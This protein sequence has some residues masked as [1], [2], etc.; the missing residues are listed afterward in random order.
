MKGSTVIILRKTVFPVLYF[1]S[2]VLAIV[3]FLYC[4]ASEITSDENVIRKLN[5]P[6]TSEQMILIV[7]A[8]MAVLLL[9][10]HFGAYNFRIK[11]F[12][13]TNYKQYIEQ[14]SI[15]RSIGRFI[16]V[17]TLYNRSKKIWVEKFGGR[18][19]DNRRNVSLFY[20]KQEG[21]WLVSKRIFNGATEEVAHILVE[22]KTGKVLAVWREGEKA[23]P[24]IDLRPLNLK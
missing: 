3:S 18:F 7:V 14:F 8:S 23:S 16:S 1:I 13:L 15:E 17:R 9:T 11:N 2:I 10:V 6:F 22:E 19:E 12:T 5:L 21:V 4:V 24:K 20:D